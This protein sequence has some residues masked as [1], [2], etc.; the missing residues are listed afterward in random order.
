MSD[1]IHRFCELEKEVARLRQKSEDDDKALVLAEKLNAAR[2][3]AGLA[4]VGAIINI[5]MALLKR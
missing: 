3:M 4:L 1:D 2:W 5:L